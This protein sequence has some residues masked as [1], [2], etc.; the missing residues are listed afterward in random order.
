MTTVDGGVRVV[1]DCP[2]DVHGPARATIT[3]LTREIREFERRDP[4]LRRDPFHLV[5]WRRCSEEAE[6]LAEKAPPKP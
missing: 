2:A 6:R 1:V 4:L 3:L 5:A